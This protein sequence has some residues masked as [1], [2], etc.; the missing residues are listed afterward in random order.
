MVPQIHQP[1]L[2]AK[3]T[4]TDKKVFPILANIGV[5]VEIM[6][7]ITCE[8]SGFCHIFDD[9]EDIPD[10]QEDQN[11]NKKPPGESNIARR[12]HLHFGNNAECRQ[13]RGSIRVDHKSE[14]LIFF[15][16][17]ATM[18]TCTRVRYFDKRFFS[19]PASCLLPDSLC[20]KLHIPF[21]TILTPQQC[22]IV[23]KNFGYELKVLTWSDFSF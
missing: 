1:K 15:F 12:K 22:T 21:S 20:S 11:D 9:D 14:E 4:E 13:V 5:P 8:M 3:K 10:N 2:P 19:I 6:G 16:P 23:K 7:I 18:H 17:R